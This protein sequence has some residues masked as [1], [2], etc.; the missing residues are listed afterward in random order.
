MRNSFCDNLLL[1]Q[2][3]K[4]DDKYEKEETNFK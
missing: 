4:G 2:E 1:L 3:D